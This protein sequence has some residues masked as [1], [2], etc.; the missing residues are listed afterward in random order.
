[1]NGEIGIHFLSEW[2]SSR[3]AVALGPRTFSLP[4]SLGRI[5]YH[6][7]A[8]RGG[9]FGRVDDARTATGFEYR[10]ELD[11]VGRFEECEC[12]SIDQWLMERYI[13]FN[14]ACDRKRSFRVWHEPWRQCRAQV[15][16]TDASLLESNWRW[17]AGAEHMGAN[18]SPG[19][20]G[21]WLGR[22]HRVNLQRPLKLSS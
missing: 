12:G 13:A 18:Y 21:V 8:T 22:P 1:V 4:Y 11:S 9:I 19:V 15:R 5:D 6:N 14:A 20:H 10:A 7:D 2:V 16:I 17:F 3:I